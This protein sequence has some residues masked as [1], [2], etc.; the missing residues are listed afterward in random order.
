[1]GEVNL[2]R[3]FVWLFCAFL[4]ERLVEGTIHVF[5][6]LDKR[7][8]LGCDVTLLLAL[9]YSVVIAYGANFNLFEMFAIPF[10]WAVFGILAA[11]ILM[12]GG[13][14]G[15]HPIIKRWFENNKDSQN[16]EAALNTST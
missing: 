13:S 8:V 16:P 15:V 4:V 14:S 9:A 10:Q 5:P 12:A 7:K 3:L 2:V 6:F 1:M 11:A